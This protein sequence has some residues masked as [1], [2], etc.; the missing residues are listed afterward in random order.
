MSYSPVKFVNFLKSRLTFNIIHCFW[1]F[2]NKLSHILRAHISKSK[3]CFNVNSS[4]F[5]FHIKTK[6]FADFQLCFSVPLRVFDPSIVIATSLHVWM[7]KKRNE[8]TIKKSFKQTMVH[9]HLCEKK[10]FSNKSTTCVTINALTLN[11]LYY[12]IT[13]NGY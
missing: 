12:W 4:S 1:M 10:Q 13:I 2:V 8:L 6:I 11:N 5:Y 3:R 7:N 9:L